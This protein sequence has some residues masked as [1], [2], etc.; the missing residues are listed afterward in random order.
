MSIVIQ[1]VNFKRNRALNHRLFKKLCQDI[2]AEFE[3]LLYHTE[4]R[5]LSRGRVL[6]R[7]FK[8]KTEVLLFL[9]ER[10]NPLFQHFERN[11]F[12]YQLAYLADIFDHIN[13]VCLSIQGPDITIMDAT[14]N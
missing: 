12:L 3:L 7:V 10:D 6:M 13:N 1:I 9:K 8:L 4:E 2:G 14:E 11:D 5:W